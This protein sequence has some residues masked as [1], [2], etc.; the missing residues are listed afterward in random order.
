[1]A[2]QDASKNVLEQSGTPEDVKA[3]ELIEDDL[4]AVSGG[5][6]NTMGAS[7]SSTNTAVCVSSD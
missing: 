2:D 1:M 5:L 4:K 7:L 3:R 6:S